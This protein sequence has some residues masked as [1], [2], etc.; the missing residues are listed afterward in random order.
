MFFVLLNRGNSIEKRRGVKACILFEVLPL[1]LIGEGYGAGREG[2]KEGCKV[3][4]ESEDERE[5][6]GEEEE[7]REGSFY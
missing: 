7:R 6:R 1:L 4:I 2:R 5:E 3:K